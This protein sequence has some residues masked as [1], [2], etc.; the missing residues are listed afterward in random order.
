MNDLWQLISSPQTLIFGIAIMLMLLLFVLELLALLLGGAND[1]VD[2]LL[3]DSLT[4]A[5]SE[6]GISHDAGIAIRFLSWLYVG[7]VP[8]L[9][10]LVVFLTVFGLL[11]FVLQGVIFGLLGFYLPSWLATVI[12]WFLSLP[13]VRACASILYKILPKDETSAIHLHELIGRTGVVVIGTAT[14]DKSAQVRVKDTHGQNHYVMAFADSEPLTQGTTV[15]LISQT[16]NDFVVIANPS[17]AL[18]D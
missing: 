17:G 5:H 1:W 10:L 18:V 8:L 9:M 3:P 11:G 7:K 4:E 16:G 6:V 15:L 13:V 14:K 2:G 12:V